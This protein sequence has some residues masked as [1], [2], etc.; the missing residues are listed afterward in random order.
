MLGETELALRHRLDQLL[1]LFGQALGHFL[2]FFR[3]ES[4]ELI[5]ERH[6]F[7]LFFRIFF[8]LGFFSRDLGFVNF[9]FAFHGQI[10][11]GA[12]RQ[13]GGDHA[14]QAGDENVVLSVVW[15]PRPRRKQ[16]QTRRRA[17]R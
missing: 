16:F 4:L 14:G 6:L 17:R 3:R 7:D 10:R 12:H 5:K 11:A 2:R 13:R 8:H 1:G 9:A 15:L